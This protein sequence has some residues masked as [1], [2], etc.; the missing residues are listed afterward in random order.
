[1]RMSPDFALYNKRKDEVAQQINNQDKEL[2]S[3]SNY[4]ELGQFEAKAVGN[5][6]SSSIRLQTIDYTYNVRGWLKNINQ[7]TENDNDLFNFSLM[8]NDIADT[9]KKLYNGNISQTSWHT[10]NT[11]SS[12]KTYSY[13]YDALNRITSAN[14]TNTDHYDLDLVAYDKNGNITALNRKGHTNIG[15]TSFGTMD[16]L[17]YDYG[18]ANGNKL[19]GVTDTGETTTG[20]KD[21]T[22]TGD[23][24]TYDTNGNLL[25]DAN[26]GITSISYN[27]LNL[28]TEVV[29]GSASNM[30]KYRYDATG[31]KLQKEVVEN[32]NPPTVTKY[33][34]GFIYEQ[35]ELQFFGQ[36]E[37]YVQKDGTGN[38]EYVY[39][40]TDHLGNVRLSYS[41][42]V[43]KNGIIEQNEIIEE[44]HYYPFG[45]KMASFN[46]VA[47]S[48]NPAQD[49]KYNGVELEE[50]LGLNMYETD[51]RH[52]DPAIARFTTIDPVTHHSMSTYTAF[53]N[54]P[55]YW[56]D[57]SG[58]DSIYN[59]NTGQY[60]INGQVVS[61]DEAIAYAQNGGNAD[62][63]N[64]NSPDDNDE[65]GTL[66]FVRTG[67]GQYYNKEKN[68]YI[69]FNNNQK[70]DEDTNIYLRAEGD[71]SIGTQTKDG[72]TLLG[73]GDKTNIGA[74]ISI[75]SI[76][77]LATLD[78]TI[79]NISYVND[80]MNLEDV[81]RSLTIEVDI[82]KS[83]LG[84][85]FSVDLN[86][87]V[88]FGANVGP[89]KGYNGDRVPFALKLMETNA[90]FLN[91]GGV[92]MI[93]VSGNLEIRFNKP[94]TV[95]LKKAK[96]RDRKKYTP[97][98]IRR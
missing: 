26:K 87:N 56:A 65:K 8:Y 44:S 30:I 12:I 98:Y 64:N 28:P 96:Y 88:D 27:H 9:T 52:Y 45:L 7:D 61:Q 3:T 34:N 80:E 76:E 58:A 86:K 42:N 77:V 13:T 55:V 21:G 40:Y 31:V 84:G 79:V 17:V 33:A 51:Y 32:G 11:D 14:G 35:D 15:A 94:P 37:G 63:S 46:N 72:G 2:I 95:N 68:I 83:Y 48:T 38:F 24:F 70:V 53:D 69:N 73:I 49:Y 66:G 20:F 43:L 85:N 59:W 18:I 91:I 67:K 74:T 19:L 71:L 10:L 6:A 60:V 92:D 4:D 29:F 22:N 82:N 39:N 23:D 81:L 5:L 93:G 47:T 62:G 54:N 16:N 25:T 41:D 90:S 50:S 78:K 36:P 1:M 57:P 89:I 97:T 75:G